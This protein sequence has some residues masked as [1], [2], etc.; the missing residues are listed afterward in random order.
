MKNGYINTIILF[1]VISLHS[2]N[3]TVGASVIRLGTIV[4]F[5]LL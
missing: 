4:P 2:S 5:G 1:V 3:I